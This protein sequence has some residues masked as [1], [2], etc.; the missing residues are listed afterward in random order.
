M[1]GKI[2]ESAPR[3]GKTVYGAALGILML[4]T[5]FPRI[6]GDIGNAETWPFP[7][8]YKIVDGAT[9][10]KVVRKG[11]AGLKDDFAKAAKE[12]V[13]M[14][15]DGIGTTCGFLSLFQDDIAKAAGVPVA[16]SSLM[17]VP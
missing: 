4:D 14:G 9:S 5:A 17:Q 2:N 13:A 16:S 6:H 8:I 12:V 15:A 7:V 3:P 1:A 10:D 11:A